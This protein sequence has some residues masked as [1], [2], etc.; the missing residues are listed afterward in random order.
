MRRMNIMLFPSIDTPALLIDLERVEQNLASMQHKADALGVDLRPHIKTH[1]IPELARRQVELGAKGITA[2][3]VS[4]A[5][6]MAEGGIG[7]IFIANQIVTEE[8]LG[9][10]AALARRVKVSVGLDSVEGARRLSQVF[11]QAGLS[12][13]YLIEI[14]SGLGRCGVAGAREAVALFN[15]A[16]AFPAIRFAGLFTHA[17]HV[18]G[19]TALEEVRQVSEAES[20]GMLAIAEA[21][22]TAGEVPGIVS[23]GSTP[24]IKV[25]KGYPGITEIRPGNYIFNDAI[26]MALG[27]AEPETCALS[28][29][30]TV[31]SRP[32]SERA[33]IDAGSKVFG[34]D[35]GGHGKESV[36]GFGWIVGTRGVVERLSEEHG[37]LSVPPESELAIGDRV[38]I[39]PNHA[40]TVM[41]LF[42]TACGVRAGR[43]E[44]TF[45]VAARGKTR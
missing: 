38:R 3:K 2:S 35:K 21:F 10:L 22:R 23:V 24:T 7:D 39:V 28:V 17:G 4:E 8:K 44:K 32:V 1:K 30:A 33:V 12:I 31:I 6:I 45:Q 14:D 25:W 42:D 41:N 37:I 19:M 18:Y 13:D 9:R 43:V 29:L 5:E 27:V 40:C 11:A 16:S 20:R 15:A 26:Q 36:S 34:L